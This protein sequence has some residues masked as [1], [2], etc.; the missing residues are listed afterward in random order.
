[1]PAQRIPNTARRTE[2]SPLPVPTTVAA[3]ICGPV[4][5]LVGT[6][7]ARGDSRTVHTGRAGGIKAA[8]PLSY[9]PVPFPTTPA[10]TTSAPAV[11]AVKPPRLSFGGFCQYCDQ[12]DCQSPQCISLH[13]DSAWIVCPDCQGRG[14]MPDAR[15]CGCLWGVTEA[16]L[17][18]AEAVA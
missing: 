17:T 16:D 7:S 14:W 1:M 10:R 8:A 5:L 13:A 9:L 6:D 18:D 2:S 3:P 11:L 12:R 15:R 4:N